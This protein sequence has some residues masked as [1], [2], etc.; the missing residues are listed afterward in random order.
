MLSHQFMQ[1]ALLAGSAIAL[2][3]GL[4][5]YFVVLRSQVF[6]GGALGDVAFTG[7]LAAAAAGLDL[8]VGLFAVTVAIAL[9]MAA[10][11][12]RAQADDVTI[13]VVLVWALGIGV[14]FLDLFNSGQAG[15]GEGAIAARTLFG[16]IFGLS[17]GQ[18]RLA[19]ALALAA[20]AV[21][22]AIARPL[23]F[24]SV[25]P[26]VARV[27]G[28][29]VRLLGA[30]F[31]VLLAADASLATQ[32][33]GAVLLLGLLSAPAGAARRLTASPGL[34]LALSVVLALGSMW[35]GLAISYAVPVLPP[36]STVILIAALAFLVTSALSAL[37]ARPRRGAAAAAGPAR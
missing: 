24:A 12:G 30:V 25:D 14:L 22:V 32:A 15:G 19:A 9:L 8:R 28:V 3:S 37:R 10:L 2:L 35:A 13:G 4:L 5:G 16:S 6:A 17:V 34:G 18:A 27:A 29:P 26:T 23:L 31:L 20:A 1:S 11:G 21:T 33:V 36:G 7:A